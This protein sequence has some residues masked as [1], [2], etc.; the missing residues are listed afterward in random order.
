MQ[1]IVVAVVE[2]CCPQVVPLIVRRG[3]P[4]TTNDFIIISIVIIIVIS[5]SII[6]VLLVALKW[7]HLL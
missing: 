2:Y 4:L 3:L 1:S 7:F 5:I 6:S